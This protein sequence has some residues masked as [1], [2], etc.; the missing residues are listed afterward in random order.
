MAILWHMK[1]N[2]PFQG[3]FRNSKNGLRGPIFY[4]NG[5]RGCNNVTWGCTDRKTLG[6][7]SPAPKMSF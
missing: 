5:L 2:M 3:K 7:E 4:L 1:Q 6:I